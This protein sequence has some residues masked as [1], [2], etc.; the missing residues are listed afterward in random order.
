MSLNIDINMIRSSNSSGLVWRASRLSWI[1]GES[2]TMWILWRKFIRTQLALHWFQIIFCWRWTS[3][4]LEVDRSTSHLLLDVLSSFPDTELNL[5]RRVVFF[6]PTWSLCHAPKWI[7]SMEKCPFNRGNIQ[8]LKIL[9]QDQP[10]CDVEPRLELFEVGVH[11][12]ILIVIFTRWTVVFI[13]VDTIQSS[14]QYIG[15]LIKYLFTLRE[16]QFL[17]KTLYRSSETCN[18]W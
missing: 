10:L 6:S 18:L 14:D 16:T 11:N 13:V 3:G 17:S 15:L 9:L 1:F 8:N 5:G 4:S 12:Q 7:S 2:A